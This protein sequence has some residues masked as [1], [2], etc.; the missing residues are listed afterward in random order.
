MP[1]GAPVEA[2]EE[3]AVHVGLSDRG[4]SL[5][6]RRQMMRARVVWIDRSR[7]RKSGRMQLG[8]VF[9]AGI[10]AGLDAA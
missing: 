8:V 9:M 4:M 6:N 7:A 3:L 5:A 1:L 10:A 2:G